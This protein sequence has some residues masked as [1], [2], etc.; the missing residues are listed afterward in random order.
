MGEWDT[1]CLWDILSLPDLQVIAF[2]LVCLDTFAPRPGDIDAHS[3]SIEF[4]SV[5]GNT[6]PEYHF[7]TNKYPNVSVKINSQ[8]LE[9]TQVGYILQNTLWINT[10]WENTLSEKS[11][12]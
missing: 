4:D 2:C 3:V 12:E 7:D 10:F 1:L 6:L 11:Q 9:D 8:S 5:D